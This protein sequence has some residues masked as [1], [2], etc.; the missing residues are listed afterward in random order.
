MPVTTRCFATASG[1]EAS[2]S[3]RSPW[4]YA[5]LVCYVTATTVGPALAADASHHIHVNSSGD[6]TDT[7]H[8]S[9]W[10]THPPG[11]LTAVVY[12][13]IG[14]IWLSIVG[15]QA[16]SWRR[17]SGEHRQQ[18][19]WLACGAAVQDG[20]VRVVTTALEPAHVSVWMTER[21]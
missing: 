14:V 16:L 11:W 17:A 7:A 20:L 19:K 5:G 2:R 21:K 1:T 6:V 13:S 15:H 10:F 8:L 18:L 12:L 3:V 9:G 4:A